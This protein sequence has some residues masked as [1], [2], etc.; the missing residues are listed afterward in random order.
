MLHAGIICPAK[1]NVFDFQEEYR[2]GDRDEHFY[3]LRLSGYK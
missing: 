2:N 1:D 3:E